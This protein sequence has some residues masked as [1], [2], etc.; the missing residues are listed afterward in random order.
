MNST[1]IHALGACA[2]VLAAGPL[3]AAD[4]ETFAKS[5]KYTQEVVAKHHLIAL[6]EIS[7][8][9]KKKP[10]EFRYD[11]YPTVERL[12]INGATYA[13]K[14]DKAWLKSEDWGETGT[15]LKAA[16]IQELDA[17]VSFADA[18]LSN[19]IIAKD[20]AQGG[21]VIEFIKR[22]QEGDSEHLFYEMR[23]ENST[24][25][26]YP[27]FVF[28][29]WKAGNDEESLLIGYAG[30]M[31]SGEEQAKVNI[32]YQYMFLVNLVEKKGAE[33]EKA[34]PKPPAD[35]DDAPADSKKPAPPADV[36]EAPMD[37]GDKVYDFM[38]LNRQKAAL[39]GKVVRVEIDATKAVG[40]DRGNGVMHAMLHDT[41]KPNGFIA[42][43][44]FPKNAYKSLGLADKS[45]KE[46]LTIYLRVKET[47][48]KG[49]A[50]FAAVGQRRVKGKGG[51][52]SYQW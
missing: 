26:F 21:T 29:P 43:V 49:T 9:E 3:C 25:V 42:L 28:R 35:P 20:K 39:K 45:G 7:P 52:P 5:L 2:F 11:R 36:P 48:E 14:K 27:Q 34:A 10:T 40:T 4:A 23:R 44:D 15:K 38:T 13:R 19:R 37:E 30:L 24:N 22:E 18:P 47:V 33:K 8:L 50:P 31:R 1:R 41:A 32:N 16:K 12:Q 6:V 51:E 46:K 17:L